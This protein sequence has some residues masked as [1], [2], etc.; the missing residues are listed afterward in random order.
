[1]RSIGKYNYHRGIEWNWLAQFFVRAEL[2]YGEADVAFRKYLRSQVDA[3]LERGGIGGI[4]ELFD[5]SG[6]R[7]P[8]YQAWSMAGLL[9]SLHAFAGVRI[10]VPERRITIEPQIPSDWP[11][12][13]VRKWFGDTPFD[14][15][16]GRHG[17]SMTLEV[18]FPQGP[19]VD[20]EIALGLLLPPRRI[21]SYLD[22]WLDGVPQS[23]GW[24]EELVSGADRQILRVS[25]PVAGNTRIDLR[26]R[27]SALRA[28][29]RAS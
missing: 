27:R 8:E 10:D 26:L 4:S 5:L 11:R 7:G 29:S 13:A 23:P 21:A 16:F 3:V 24:R 20:T 28:V 1:M 9:E 15:R 12:L 18:D 14:V 6:A 22:L 25:L 2:K 19:P 17:C